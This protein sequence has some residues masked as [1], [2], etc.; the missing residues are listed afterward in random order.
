MPAFIIGIYSSDLRFSPCPSRCKTAMYHGRCTI[1]PFWSA[2]FLSCCHESLSNSWQLDRPNIFNPA[3][4]LM[5]CQ[6]SSVHLINTAI[7]LELRRLFHSF[8]QTLWG[9]QIAFSSLS[10]HWLDLCWKSSSGTINLTA[11]VCNLQWQLQQPL[12]FTHSSSAM[13]PGSSHL[14]KCS[15]GHC[16]KVS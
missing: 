3:S 10:L 8:F 6:L 9:D 1:L 12:H 2:L 4:T 15:W 7:C 5:T 11:I 16:G 13:A 14:F